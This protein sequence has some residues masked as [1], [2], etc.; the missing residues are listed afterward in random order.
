MNGNPYTKHRNPFEFQFSY[1]NVDTVEI[2]I[3]FFVAYCIAVPL[4]IYALRKRWHQLTKLLTTCM[5]L[6]FVGIFLNVVHVLKFALDGVGEPNC[7]MAGNLIGIIAECLVI[8][9]L[10]LVAKGWTITRMEVTC[11]F[12]VFA[13]WT[14]YTCVYIF[15][16]V[17]NLVC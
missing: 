16:F 9:M 15:L 13:V 1:D 2:Y 7:N 4:Q 14:A 3:V 17:W 8:L 12:L 11:K 5:V 6:E 10:L